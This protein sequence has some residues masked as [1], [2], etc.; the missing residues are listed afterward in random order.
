MWVYHDI[1][2]TALLRLYVML[3]MMMSNL[4]VMFT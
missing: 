4:L 1:G 2:S 3:L